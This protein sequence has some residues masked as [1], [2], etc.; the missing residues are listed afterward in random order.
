METD[1]QKKSKDIQ[2]SDLNNTNTGSEKHRQYQSIEDGKKH[3][4]RLSAQNDQME[5]E[6]RYEEEQANEIKKLEEFITI[7]AKEYKECV[8]VDFLWHETENEAWFEIVKFAHSKG[9]LSKELDL[10]IFLSGK[11]VEGYDID[12]EYEKIYDIF[13]KDIEDGNVPKEAV[14]IYE[15]MMK[16]FYLNPE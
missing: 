14:S 16:L 5:V 11:E 3:Y 4:A 9:Y 2:N 6:E 15:L 10:D 7:K 8:A 12:E 1:E 13:S